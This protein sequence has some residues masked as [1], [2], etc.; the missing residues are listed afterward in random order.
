MSLAV[1]MSAAQELGV[2]ISFMSALAPLS[3]SFVNVHKAQ[4]FD[5]CCVSKVFQE[6]LQLAQL[7]HNDV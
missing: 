5:T 3:L 7:S 6:E 2:T 1:E 4:V